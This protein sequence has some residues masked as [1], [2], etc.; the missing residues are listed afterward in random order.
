MVSGGDINEITTTSETSP[1]ER[2]L[3]VV[4]V[5]AYSWLGTL[6][7]STQSKNESLL[8]K[9]CM[10]SPMSAGFRRTLHNMPL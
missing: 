5:N 8:E 4:F 6:F 10:S 9:C 7:A 1:K 3:S 2:P